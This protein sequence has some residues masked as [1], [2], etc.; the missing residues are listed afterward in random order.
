MPD[1]SSSAVS[2]KGKKGADGDANSPGTSAQG[3]GVWASEVSVTRVVWNNGGGLA[4]APLLAS[5]TASGLCRIDWLLGY[6]Q[7]GKMP[8]ENVEYIRK[9]GEAGDHIQD[10]E[11]DD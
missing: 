8:Y 10:D 3:T 2:K 11:D 6:F 9:E 4:R 7:N 1:R 5:A